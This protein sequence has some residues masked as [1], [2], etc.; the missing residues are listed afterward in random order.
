MPGRALSDEE[1]AR[2]GLIEAPAK[3]AKVKAPRELSDKEA[4]AL[5]LTAPVG[6]DRSSM[7][8]P[9]GEP[10]AT[11]GSG[12]PETTDERTVRRFNERLAHQQQAKQAT[13]PLTPEQIAATLV[14]GAAANGVAARLLPKVATAPGRVAVGAIAGAVGGGVGGGTEAALNHAASPAP[15]R[16]FATEAAEAMKAGAAGGALYGAALGSF[17]EGVGKVGKSITEGLGKRIRNEIAEGDAGVATTPT[18]RKKLTA[19][20]DAVV[21]E[22]VRDPKVRKAYMSGAEAGRTQL[23]PLIDTIGG[24]LDAAYDTFTAAGKGNV[25]LVDYMQR[26]RDASADALASGR[27]DLQRGIQAFEAEVRQAAEDSGQQLTLRQL[28]GLTTQTQRAASSALGGLNEHAAAALKNQITAVATEQMAGALEKAAG[29]DKTLTK[30]LGQIR[31]NNDRMH[32]LL[33]IDGALK[34]RA[35]K[36]ETAPGAFQNAAAVVGSPFKKGLP[37]AGRVVD[38]AVTAAAIRAARAG[39]QPVGSSVVPFATA[40]QAATDRDEEP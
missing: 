28:R 24:K 3:P 7:R 8:P 38:R 25:N 35:F 32:A 18:E 26:L 27:T 2:L 14:G 22:V 12:P 10:D 20:G 40:A 29:G 39:E 19:A 36:E 16:G 6:I 17:A 31:L 30:A 4:A 34:R 33:T 5:G 13:F 9:E 15:S 1:A 21:R 11:V 37:A 23:Q